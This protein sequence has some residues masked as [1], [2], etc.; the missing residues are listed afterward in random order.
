MNLLAEYIT[1]INIADCARNLVMS[2]SLN[3]IDCE[4]QKA[5]C[6]T[7]LTGAEGCWASK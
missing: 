1:E 3:K 4:K 6:N 7:S 5:Q 2:Q